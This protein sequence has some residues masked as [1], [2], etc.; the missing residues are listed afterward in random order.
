MGEKLIFLNTDNIET[1][2]QTIYLTEI[3]ENNNKKMFK[4]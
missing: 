2:E 1:R 3:N 4:F